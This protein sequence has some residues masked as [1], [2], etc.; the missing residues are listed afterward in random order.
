MFNKVNGYIHQKQVSINTFCEGI[1]KIDINKIDINE[2]NSFKEKMK[3]IKGIDARKKWKKNI[4]DEKISVKDYNSHCYNAFKK[5]CNII[6]DDEEKKQTCLK[7]FFENEQEENNWST[8]N[9]H[10]YLIVRNGKIMKI[11]GTRTGMKERWNSYL[12]GHCV[13]E[14]KNKSGKN[15]PGKMSVTNAHL[16]HTIEDD[17]LENN[18]CWEFWSWKLPII[19]KIVNILGDETEIIVQTYH[20]YESKCI[21]KFNSL[22]GKIPQLCNNCDP[23][24]N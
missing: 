12:C 1:N 18:S 15:Y 7:V 9:E 11:G 23:N 17:L 5:I 4:V 16:Y 22:S 24:Y 14:R 2:K 19:K 13:P 21:G 3:F 6:L 20:A 10:I 8:R